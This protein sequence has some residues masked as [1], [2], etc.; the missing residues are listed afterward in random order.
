MIIAAPTPMAPR[1]AISSLGAFRKM[2]ASEE[3]PKMPRP[4]ARTGLRPNPI[5]E[6]AGRKKQRCERE[7]VRGHDPLQLRLRGA[8][9]ARDLRQRHVQAGDSADDHH[10]REAHDSQHR[11]ALLS[12]VLE[13][14]LLSITRLLK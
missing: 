6:R 13:E 7:R 8:R 11:F 2:A 3:R 9:A 4:A 12:F 5:S 10:Q 1:S 14:L